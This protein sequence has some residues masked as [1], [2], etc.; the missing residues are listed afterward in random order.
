MTSAAVAAGTVDG[1]GTVAFWAVT[2]E[3]NSRL[4]AVG[5]LAASQAVTTGNTF[6]LGAFDIKV[7][8]S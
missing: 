2:D 4:L 3:T 5:N 6:S 8:N 7:L 1:T